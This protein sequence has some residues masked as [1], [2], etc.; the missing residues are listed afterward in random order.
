MTSTVQTNQPASTPTNT[1]AP[2]TRTVSKHAV[3]GGLSGAI[4]GLLMVGALIFFCFRRRQ[5]RRDDDVGESTELDEKIFRPTL[6]RKWTVFMAQATPKQTPQISPVTVD[7]EHHIIRMSTQHWARPYAPGTGEGYRESMPAGAL[8]VVNPD[9]SRPQ[10]PAASTDSPRGYLFKQRS[11][12]ATVLLSASGNR[13]RASSRSGN[14]QHIPEITIDPALSRECIAP[15][16]IPP[17][18][19]SYPSV[20]S[21]A[22]VQQQPPEDPFVTPPEKTQEEMLQRALKRPGLAPIQSAASLAQRT[23][24]HVLQPF[25]SKSNMTINHAA[26][27]NRSSISSFMTRQRNRDTE[28]SDP[29]DLDRPSIR[30]VPSAYLRSTRDYEQRWTMTQSRYEGS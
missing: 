19:K 22:I 29:F 28:Y 9:R 30:T 12:L 4:A 23:L 24:S 21:L 27:S 2:A 10:T 13:S 26:P 11:A 14:P 3:V 25:R 5:R 1:A 8:R 7:E 20:T 6:L 18:F 16:A 17:S 15:T